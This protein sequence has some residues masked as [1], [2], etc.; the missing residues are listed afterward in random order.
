MEQLLEEGGAGLAADIL[1]AAPGTSIL[2]TSRTRLEIRGEQLFSV[3]GMSLPEPEAVRTWDDPQAEAEQYGGLRLF[4]QAARRIQ[5][6]FRLTQGNIAAVARIGQ[7]VQGMPLGLEL[8]ACWLDLLSPAEITAEIDRSLDVLATD[9]RDVPE[10]QRSMRAVF[11]TT[12]QFLSERERALLLPLS[13]FRAPFSR[14]AA[15]AV[16]GASLRDLM[17]LAG[18]SWL[19]RVEADS[20]S[21]RYQM[22]ELLRQFAEERLEADS[23]LRDA[24]NR[25]FIHFYAGL[26]ESSFPRLIGP[27]QLAARDNL[28]T[29]LENVTVAWNLAVDLGDFATAA[30]KM[31]LPLFIYG[32]LRPGLTIIDQLLEQAI[33]ARDAVTGAPEDDPT[34]SMLRTARIWRNLGTNRSELAV[35]IRPAWDYATRHDGAAEALGYWYIRLCALAGLVDDLAG[36]VRRLREWVSACQ[37]DD[38]SWTAVE[39][40]RVLGAVLLFTSTSQAELAEA[41]EQFQRAAEGFRRAGNRVG[42][43]EVLTELAAIS[44]RRRAYAEALDRL[45]E[46]ESLL[47][48]SGTSALGWLL[49]AKI[50][51]FQ[52]QGRIDEMFAALAEQARVARDQGDFALE[53]HAYSF[54]SVYALRYSTPEHARRARLAVIELERLQGND[55]SDW[56]DFELGEIAR[57]TGDLAT[58]R[59]LYASSANRFERHDNREGMAYCERAFGDLA[60]ASGDFAAAYHHYRQSLERLP[61][62]MHWWPEARALAGLARAAAALGRFDES[63]RGIAAALRITDSNNELDLA[64]VALLALAELAAARQWPAAALMLTGLMSGA[65]LTW[66]ET[67]D[68][69][70]RVEARARER[71]GDA[72]AEAARQQGSRIDLAALIAGLAALPDLDADDWLDEAARVI[73]SLASPEAA[74]S[75]GQSTHED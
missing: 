66:N 1:D 50:D 63:A 40:R 30:D 70:A 10:R 3:P 43:A 27:E 38:Q 20:G 2:A 60:L 58:A 47:S 69:S 25:R 54:E 61:K 17:A 45:A 56:N 29:D 53:G 65:R 74:S 68:Q 57:V 33:A 23:A 14:E 36:G 35:D 6:D 21:S 51:M 46:A 12:W 7:Q 22:H 62:G 42:L 34:Q 73:G 26:L 5:P 16:A 72:A 8:A 11:E 37:P 13:A 44:A 49:D 67:R 28:T 18:K 31:L 55:G 52:K 71:V 4:A 41:E 9:F 64:T 39:A 75:N 19:Q 24:I 48:A 59:S 32:R 15:E